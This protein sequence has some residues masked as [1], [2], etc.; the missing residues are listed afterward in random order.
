MALLLKGALE[1]E[2]R[3]G[4]KMNVPGSKV[5]DVVAALPSITAPTVAGLYGTDGMSGEI[6]VFEHEV[7]GL[8]P[9]LHAKGAKGIIEYSLNKSV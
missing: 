1:A 2:S 4:I 5:G 9:E 3:V 7:R 8:I 6:V